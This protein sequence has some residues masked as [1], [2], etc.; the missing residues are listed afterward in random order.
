MSVRSYNGKPLFTV[1]F[2]DFAEISE[3]VLLNK[4]LLS[5]NIADPELKKY[6]INSRKPSFAVVYD[7]VIVSYGGR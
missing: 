5:R 7:D 6:F 4:R 1:G 2:G 3:S